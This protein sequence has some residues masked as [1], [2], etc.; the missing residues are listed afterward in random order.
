[1]Q[2]HEMYWGTQ[3]YDNYDLIPYLMLAITPVG[4]SRAAALA[5]PP[6]YRGLCYALGQLL[7]H[8]SVA[9]LQA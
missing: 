4:E 5:A 9:R 3:T 7:R 2:I 8:E 1:M 6:R